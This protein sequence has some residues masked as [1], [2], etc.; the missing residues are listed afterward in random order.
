MSRT[1]DHQ[2]H[3]QCLPK[4]GAMSSTVKLKLR[5]LL[6]AACAVLCGVLGTVMLSPTN[7]AATSVSRPAAGDLW[8]AFG[9]DPMHSG[10]SSDS[11]ISAS[12]ASGLAK[13]WSVSLSS[14]YE[15]PSPAVAYSGKLGETVV[16]AVTNGGVVS[17]FDAVTG[18]LVWQRSVGS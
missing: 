5:E 8:P 18:K 1:S 17:A 7:A 13:R 11:A 2:A 16:Y 14:F 3:R 4:G 10:V 12:T 15:Q 9:H 6:V